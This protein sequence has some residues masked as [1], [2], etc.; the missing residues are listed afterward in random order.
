MYL[1]SKVEIPKIEGKISE[2]R[3]NNTTYI[4]YIV[5]RKYQK[6]KKYNI[7][8]LKTIGKAINAEPG[9]M[10]P[11][12]NYLKY[13]G[14]EGI[15]ELKV[16]ESRSSCLRVGAFLVIR[17]LIE[18][19]N[20]PKLLTQHISYKDAALILDMAAYSIVCEDNAA[21]Y[22]PMYAY[23][24]PLFT[25]RM[26][27]YSD[28]K[29]SSLLAGITD[30]TRIGFLNTWNAT[31]DHRE[32]IWISYDSTNKNCQAGDIRMLEFGHPKD[33]KDLPIFNYAIAYDTENKEP[34]FYEQYPGSIVDI[35]Q[36]RL[37]LDKAEGYGYRRVGFILDRGY[38]CRENLRYL[39]QHGYEFVIMLKGMDSTVNK[40]ILEN[41]G[42]FENVREYSI[43]S[44]KVYGRTIRK[45]LYVSDDTERYI[46]LYYSDRKASTEH[47]NFEG[48]LDRMAG[49]LEKAKGTV[50]SFGSGFKDYYE[51]FFYESD[52]TF[53]TYRERTDKIQEQIDLCGYFVLVTSKKMSAKEAL[54]LYKSRDVSEKV[55][56]GDKSY[57]DNKSLRISS[58]EA[59]NGKIFVEFLALIL[60]CKLHD[61]LREEIQR[62]EK[63]PNFMTVPASIRELDKIEMVRSL[64]G[65]YR[66][67]HAVTATQKKILKAF[68]LDEFFVQ[69]EIKKLSE[70]LYEYDRE[71]VEE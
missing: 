3:K 32:K 68:N 63:K 17:K 43:R 2:F 48:R 13:F 28:S 42:T 44:H 10:I 51:L 40:W 41:K 67:D 16:V 27:I 35:S 19:S 58:D 69:R 38:F 4:R 12:E 25:E 62:L 56:R 22:Y 54:D 7:P 53:I 52:G 71:R 55:F 49:V 1:D 26:H 5:G 47:E 29:I 57:L 8:D 59:A 61:K 70:M 24:H 66:M 15:S 31:R 60:R 20:L 14:D 11:N 45:K 33:D 30:D 9:Y 39:D 23:N 36:I 34:L 6:E 21:Q 46:H 37:M 50:T 18:D 65:R 64:D